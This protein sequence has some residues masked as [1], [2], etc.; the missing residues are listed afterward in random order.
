[1]D[2]SNQQCL[3][4]NEGNSDIKDNRTQR[5]SGENRLSFGDPAGYF[6]SWSL[7]S[8]K[9]ISTIRSFLEPRAETVGRRKKGVRKVT[10]MPKHFHCYLVQKTESVFHPA[11]LASGANYPVGWVQMPH[12][13]RN[14]GVGALGKGKDG[15]GSRERSRPGVKPLRSVQRRTEAACRRDLTQHLLQSTSSWQPP[16]TPTAGAAVG[17]WAGFRLTWTQT[18]PICVVLHGS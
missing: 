14:G 3:T 1:M 17:R 12:S 4:P 8:I 13:V 7:L 9:A 6:Q 15:G 11:K 5:L 10:L 2:V 18:K 16:S